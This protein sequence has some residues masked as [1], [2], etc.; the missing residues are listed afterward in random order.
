MSRRAI[1]GDAASP[2]C[3]TAAVGHASDGAIQHDGRGGVSTCFGIDTDSAG[4]FLR[5]DDR[6]ARHALQLR[7]RSVPVRFAHADRL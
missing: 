7:Q 1:S 5:D 6:I 2:P 4:L 3:P